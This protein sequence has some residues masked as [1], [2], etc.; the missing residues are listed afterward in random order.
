MASAEG[1]HVAVDIEYPSRSFHNCILIKRLYTPVLFALSPRLCRCVCVRF[2]SGGN[3]QYL[4]T[5]YPPFHPMEYGDAYTIRFSLV[6]SLL[7]A[8]L[9]SNLFILA[10]IKFTQNIFSD[11]LSSQTRFSH[12]PIVYMASYMPIHFFCCC[13]CCCRFSFTLTSSSSSIWFRFKWHIQSYFLSIAFFMNKHC[14][15][16]IINTAVAAAAAVTDA[17][18]AATVTVVVDVVIL[19]WHCRH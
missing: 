16:C 2:A 5:S 18:A 15:F 10:Y 13:C 19:C 7:L 3:S 11:L 17:A 4:S 6:I 12:S 8:N 9:L 1:S 14:W